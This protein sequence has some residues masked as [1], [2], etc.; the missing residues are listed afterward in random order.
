MRLLKIFESGTIFRRKILIFLV[1]LI[2]LISIIEIWVVNRL[3]TY[4]EQINKLSQTKT[5]LT[6]ENQILKNQISQK[7]SL[8]E[9]GQ[10]AAGLGYE[11]IKNVEYINSF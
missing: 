7:G 8:Q 9:I 5:S 4:G 6:L 11:K 2:F 3:S 10:K 1:L